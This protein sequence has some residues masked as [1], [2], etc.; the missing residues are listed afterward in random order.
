MGSHIRHME[1]NPDTVKTIEM[2]I[3]NHQTYIYMFH[4]VVRSFKINKISSFCLP[5]SS[6]KVYSPFQKV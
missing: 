3:I 1:T 4:T 6:K 5:R 2:D